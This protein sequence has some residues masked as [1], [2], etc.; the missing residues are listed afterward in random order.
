[1]GKDLPRRDRV[2]G[3]RGEAFRS[4]GRHGVTGQDRAGIHQVHLEVERRLVAGGPV[5]A[6]PLQHHAD[7]R[8]FELD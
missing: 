8:V 6:E 2:K 7:L 1:M 3:A 5:L 4:S